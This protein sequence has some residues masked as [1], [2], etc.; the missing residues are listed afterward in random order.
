MKIIYIHQYFRT[1]KVQGSTRSYEFSKH[2][3]NK[4]HAVTMITSGI[5]NPQFPVAEG[6]KSSE[7]TC[8][9]IKIIALRAGYNNAGYGSQLNGW[10]RMLSF[11]HFAM[12]ATRAG[13]VHE[14]PEV[15][16]ATHTPLTV[17]FTGINLQKHFNVPF[18]FEVRDLWPEA[19]VN[20]DAI[21]N[22]LVIA[23]L[24]RWSRK[25]YYAADELIAA[26]PGMKQGILEYG[27]QDDKVTVVTQGCDLDIFSPTLTGHGVRARLGLGD[28]FAA[29][30]FGAMSFANGLDFAVEAGSILKHRGRNDIVIVLHGE[31]S[32]R[33]MLKAMA[34]SRNLDNVVFSDSVPEK[35]ELAKIVAA[36]DVCLTI[37]RAAKEHTWSPN[38]MFDALA[39]GKPILINVP[40]WLG[41]TIQANKCG[42]MTDPQD[43]SSLADRLELL[44]D[45][46]DMVKEF[47]RN[48]RQ[49]AETVFSRAIMADRLE[50]VLLGA[51]KNT[52]RSM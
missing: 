48:S 35:S 47:S 2:L 29:I 39:A 34:R 17:G 36:C 13:K 9:G 43:P 7:Y 28:R 26:S 52:G 40:G 15:V 1:P 45:D 6:Q 4:G 20:I 44:A 30:Y 51:V 41:N 8:E 32:K 50:T 46:P 27:I 11:A 21:K 38:K 22:P 33:Q 12:A 16:F 23:L 3:I 31:G 5:N 49:L 42:F 19:L 25:I 18:I 10:R 14:N 37:Y 24:R